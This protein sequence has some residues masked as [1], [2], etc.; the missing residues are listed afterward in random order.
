MGVWMQNKQFT[1]KYSAID[2]EEI[3]IISERD[4]I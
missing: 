2:K 4:Y 3:G 1:V